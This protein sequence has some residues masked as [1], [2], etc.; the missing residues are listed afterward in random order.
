MVGNRDQLGILSNTFN[1]SNP[2]KTMFISFIL[3]II[4][5]N[6][7]VIGRSSLIYVCTRQRIA[8]RD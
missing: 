6:S 4:L 8:R 2:E 1:L 7:C 3:I 5:G